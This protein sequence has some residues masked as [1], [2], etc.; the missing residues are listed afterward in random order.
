MRLII[1]A[2]L[3]LT[4]VACS[5]PTAE[6]TPAAAQKP[7][8]DQK[9]ATKTAGDL[10]DRWTVRLD[11]PAAK[12]DAV[13]LK[14]ETEAVEIISGPAGIYYKGGE[15]AEKD[16]TVSAAFS[17][18]KPTPQPVEYGL[19]ISG[20]DLDKPAARYTA[21]LVRGDGKYRIVTSNAGKQTPIVDWTT[22]APMMEPKGAKT[23]NTLTIRAL[24]DGVHFLIG[25]KELHQIPRTK[26][27]EDG[28]AGV[29]FGSGL[30]IQITKFEAKKFP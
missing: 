3:A 24:Q 19:F 6:Q 28:I 18:L 17:Q 15:K 16:Y 7:A 4:V 26:A 22:A 9:P 23:S 11:D 30:N 10:F 21:F 29:R 13:S 2:T 25:E 5:A 12:P 14:T 27:G 1:A 8:S 20:A